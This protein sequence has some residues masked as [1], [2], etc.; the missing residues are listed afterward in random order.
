TLRIS[1]VVSDGS[2][3]RPSARLSN[4]SILG[5]RDALQKMKPVQ[6]RNVATIGGAV[7][8]SIASTCRYAIIS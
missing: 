4:P 8:V 1:S 5:V 2:S 3:S 6:V 7:C